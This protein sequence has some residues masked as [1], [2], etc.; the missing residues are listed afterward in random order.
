MRRGI[1]AP[2]W[3]LGLL[4]AAVG[5]QETTSGP[6][7]SD[8]QKQRDALVARHQ[9]ESGAQRPGQNAVPEGEADE[10]RYGASS[11]AFR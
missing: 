2:A 6:A 9:V 8:Y 11:G 4:L 3:L 1:A 5:C 7:V 10:T